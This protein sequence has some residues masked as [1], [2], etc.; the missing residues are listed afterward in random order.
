MTR[1]LLG[2]TLRLTIP[3]AE[4]S[5]L[6]IQPGELLLL[7]E[8]GLDICK[9]LLFLPSPLA[10][11]CSANPQGLRASAIAEEVQSWEQAEVGMGVRASFL[12]ALRALFIPF[13]ERS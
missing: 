10:S 6:H 5:G 12:L 7:T 1:G 11:A 9:T 3:H 4:P 8:E 13:A 2:K